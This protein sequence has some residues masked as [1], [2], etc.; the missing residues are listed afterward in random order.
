MKECWLEYD[1]WCWQKGKVPQATA[2]VVYYLARC[3]EED[4][5]KGWQEISQHGRFS[6][7]VSQALASQ[8][9][10]GL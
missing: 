6:E 5:T 8:G 1:R 2:E 7:K 9:G 3:N 10:S 4:K